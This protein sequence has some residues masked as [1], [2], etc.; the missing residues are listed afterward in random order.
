MW[1][2]TSCGNVVR[3]Q[4]LQNRAARIITQK[5]YETRSSVIRQQL[6]WKSLKDHRTAHSLITMHQIL[7][8]K[9]PSYLRDHFKISD[10]NNIYSLRNKKMTLVLSKPR[11]EFL[12]Q[13][14]SYSG[15]K[16][17]NNLPEDI[18][19]NNNLRSIKTY[20]ISQPVQTI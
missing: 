16:L 18:R 13:S 10:L 19:I 6:N 14:F 4:K 7:Y 2:N 15:A 20:L 8:N 9:A 11:T 3:L 17:W 5:G 1:S 12:K